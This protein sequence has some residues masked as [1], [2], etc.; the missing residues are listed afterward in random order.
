MEIGMLALS[1]THLALAPGA[2]AS[3]DHLWRLGGLL[4]DCGDD[5]G[6]TAPVVG[7]M[8]EDSSRPA[9]PRTRIHPF[10]LFVSSVAVA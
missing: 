5:L 4:G 1:L 8:P 6:L 7:L 2:F 3:M 9:P 10:F